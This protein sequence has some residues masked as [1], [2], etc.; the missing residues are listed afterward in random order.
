MLAQA[1]ATRAAAAAA[2]ARAR[3]RRYARGARRG[4]REPRL[5][6]R[7]TW[8]EWW[9]WFPNVERRSAATD[10]ADAPPRARAPR[11][12]LSLD[13][14]S[15]FQQIFNEMDVNGDGG[16]SASELHAMLGELGVS[17]TRDDAQAMVD[18]AD[19]DGNGEIDFEEFLA[20]VSQRANRPDWQLWWRGW[21][22]KRKEGQQFREVP[23][24]PRGGPPAVRGRGTGAVP[25]TPRTARGAGA[26]RRRRAPHAARRGARTR[27]ASGSRRR[28]ATRARSTSRRAFCMG[29]RAS[30]AT[31]SARTSA[32]STARTS[33]G[34]ACSRSAS[35]C[36]RF[37]RRA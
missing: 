20:L 22:P 13:Q 7:A 6:G 36:T 10:A 33:A 5:R 19:A 16:L 35:S 14:I 32:S 25:A 28:R 24:T 8:E 18:A 2:A 17:A 9:G 23:P 4:D 29:A 11:E 21:L 37:A 27:R 15:Q 3:T 34:T 26:G 1:S 31:R 30:R 12:V